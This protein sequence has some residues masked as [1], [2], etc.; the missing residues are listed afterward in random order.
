MDLDPSGNSFDEVVAVARELHR[1]LKEV[2]IKNSVPKTSGKKGMHIYIPLKGAY[3]YDVARDVAKLLG[4]TL[5]NRLPK[6]VSMEH[7]PAKRRGKI[8]PDYMR[9]LN[10]GT[11]PDEE[12]PSSGYGIRDN[13]GVIEFR[14]SGGTWKAISSLGGSGSSGNT[15]FT[16]SSDT[17]NANLYVIAGSPATAG[18]YT[19]TINA[20]V[21]VGSASTGSASLSTGVWPAGS[22]VLL[23]NNGNIYGRGGAGGGGG[24][25]GSYSCGIASTCYSNSPGGAGGAGGPAM[26]L[27]YNLTINNTNGTIAGGGGGGGAYNGSS[28][29]AGGAGQGSASVSGPGAGTIMPDYTGAGSGGSGGALAASGAGGANGLRAGTPGYGS[30][31]GAGGAG[32]AAIFLN[33][34][35][36]TWLGGNNATHV[37]GAVQ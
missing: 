7:Y 35:T 10:F 33:G 14:D 26:S 16:I 11:I 8:H 34:K 20:G 2:G 31:G 37:K 36:V 4:E 32:G 28:G 1:L 25:S 21:T 13:N 19:V 24:T 3:S 12:P 22:T 6:L 29:G 23:I 30:Y 9:N 5:W 27:N 15:N 17:Q 18:T